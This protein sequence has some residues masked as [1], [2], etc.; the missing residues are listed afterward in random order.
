M[1]CRLIRLIA[2][3]PRVPILPPS[4]TVT[5]VCLLV[6]RNTGL[7]FVRPPTHNA[8]WRTYSAGPRNEKK[9]AWLEQSTDYN[10][11][12]W[13]LTEIYKG[14]LCDK[15]GPLEAWVEF[16]SCTTISTKISLS[17][18]H[19]EFMDRPT[20]NTHILSIAGY[21]DTRPNDTF[22]QSI[23]VPVSSP[24]LQLISWPGK[25]RR[26]LNTMNLNIPKSKPPQNWQKPNTKVSFIVPVQH[27]V[28]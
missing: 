19:W 10:W 2:W 16:P 1:T 26:E 7:G 25:S 21:V 23:R 8:I 13:S 15:S 5:N 11:T 24:Y 22:P 3:P 6:C 14:S 4:S 28:I 17:R 27:L 20:Q 9:E 12:I 18:L